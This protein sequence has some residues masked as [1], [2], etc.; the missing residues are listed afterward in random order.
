[1]KNYFKKSLLWLMVATMV[2]AMCLSMTACGDKEDA[3][4]ITETPATEAAQKEYRLEDLVRDARSKTYSSGSGT[5]SYVIPEILLDSNDAK[6]AN[7]E[8][9]EKNNPYFDDI[10]MNASN[11]VYQGVPDVMEIEYTASLVDGVLS[12][13]VIRH[14]SMASEYDVYNFDVSKGELLDNKAFCAK[15][16]ENYADI[17]EQIKAEIKEYYKQ[18]DSNSD[19]SYQSM[20]QENLNYSL[21]G[22]NLAF[23]KI[24]YENDELKVTY[25]VK[26][27]AGALYYYN[28]FT[29]S[30]TFDAY[31]D[32]DTPVS[33]DD[34]V[35][36]EI[37][38]ETISSEEAAVI[39]RQEAGGDGFQAI[40]E[41][42]VEYNGEDYYMF[43]IKWR[44]DD[45]NGMFHYSRIGNMI[46][47]LDGSE[48]LS[49]DYDYNNDKMYVY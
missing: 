22:E 35:Q 31:E 32:S 29:V 23:A 42:I 46:V 25:R 41:G 44:V 18:Y 27:M 7:S 49:G 11:G 38:P 48:V 40:Y 8:I 45:G 21:S 39:A 36:E 12:V 17:E 30:D 4:E 1:M 13:T 24:F 10:D 16:G 47:S 26:G 9:L 43:N 19:A 5:N 33:Q 37:E 15:V 2:L 14:M 34:A 6:N 28:T 20:K 3:I